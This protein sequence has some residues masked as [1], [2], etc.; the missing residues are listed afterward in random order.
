MANKNLKTQRQ[1]I[2]VAGRLKEVVTVRDEKGTILHKLMSPIMVEFYARDVM[3]VVVGATILAIPVAFTEETW[4][5]GM[6]LPLGNV[7]AI[8]GVS[9]V[10]IASFVYYNFYKGR[11]HGN[12]DEFVKRVVS[13][14]VISFLVVAL[15]LTIIQ[16]APWSTDMLLAVKR[17]ILVSL[18][19]SMSAAVAD[20]IK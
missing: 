6:S 7:L 20:M 13:T 16:R 15:L 1:T 12:K 5:L 18:P 4:N 14:Y 2:R 8:L 3:Q 10:F 11:M 19:A 17:V 9:L